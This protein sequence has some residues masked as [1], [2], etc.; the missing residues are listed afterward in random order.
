MVFTALN[1]AFASG[2]SLSETRA[3]NCAN[4]TQGFLNSIDNNVN[5]SNANS[6]ESLIRVYH[7]PA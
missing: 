3:H 6:M 1:G 4:E 7:R 5:A 2:L